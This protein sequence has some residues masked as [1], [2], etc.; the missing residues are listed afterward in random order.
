MI[1]HV[2]MALICLALIGLN[3]ALGY[4]GSRIVNRHTYRHARRL[5]PGSS[6]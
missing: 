2:V 4:Y 6:R 5:P 3:F 1:D